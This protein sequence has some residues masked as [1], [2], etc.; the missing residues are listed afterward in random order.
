MFNLEIYL[1]AYYR[2]DI[3]AY[4]SIKL[5]QSDIGIRCAYRTSYFG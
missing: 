1:I 3:K 5:K 2:N 4:R